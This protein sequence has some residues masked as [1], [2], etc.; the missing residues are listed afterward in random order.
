MTLALRCLA[1]CL[2]LAGVSCSPKGTAPHADESTVRAFLNRYFDT[3]SRQDMTGYE[4]CFD[5]QARVYLLDPSNRVVMTQGLTDFLHGQRMAHQQTTVP[6]TESP[7][8]MRIQMDRRAAQAQV[9]WV[10]K[11]GQNEERG[12]DM[13]TLRREG[14]DWKI[15]SLMF[16]G[17]K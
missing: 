2:L 15:V 3:W 14:N 12:T 10:L 1:L 5:S 8:E 9:T 16:Y 17:E 4:A 13:F 7:L 6:M 11:K